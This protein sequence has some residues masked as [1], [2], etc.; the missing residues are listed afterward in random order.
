M[1]KIRKLID[2]IF[3]E[4]QEIEYFYFINLAFYDTILELQ[5]A[6]SFRVRDAL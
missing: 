1:M 6:L 4:L 2:L 3:V 5:V